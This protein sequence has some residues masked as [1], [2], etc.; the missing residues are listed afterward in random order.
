MRIFRAW[1][2]CAEVNNQD[3]FEFQLST[4]HI[5]VKWSW[6]EVRL[7]LS[8]YR[9]REQLFKDKNTKMTLWK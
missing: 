2:T 8:L 9:D 1:A 7:L 6:P 5:Q 3:N 4:T